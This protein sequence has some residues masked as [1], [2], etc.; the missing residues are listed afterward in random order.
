LE[1]EN[2]NAGPKHD[3]AMIYALVDTSMFLNKSEPK[4]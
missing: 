2:K 1:E 3:G 4:S